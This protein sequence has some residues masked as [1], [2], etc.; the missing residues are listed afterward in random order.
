MAYG[1]DTIEAIAEVINRDLNPKAAAR[2]P[3]SGLSPSW[4]YPTSASPPGPRPNAPASAGNNTVKGTRREG[5]AP[6]TVEA[7]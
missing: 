2:V 7:P 3:P 5:E 6:M 4:G 1:I